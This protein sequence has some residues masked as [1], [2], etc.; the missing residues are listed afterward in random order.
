MWITDSVEKTLMLGRTEGRRRRGWQRMRWLDGITNLMDRS[1][2]KLQELVMDRGVWQSCSPWGRKELDTTEQLNWTVFWTYFCH[3]L[4]TFLLSG[5][6][7]YLR[8]SHTFHV[9]VMESTIF[10]F[11]FFFFWGGLVPFSR[12]CYLEGF[13]FQVCALLLGYH[14]SQSLSGHWWEIGVCVWMYMNV[15]SSFFWNTR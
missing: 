5:T 14:C 13:G 3:S 4:S 11:F 9:P 6:V 2:S 12:K 8:S 1:L 10:S 7:W 15:K